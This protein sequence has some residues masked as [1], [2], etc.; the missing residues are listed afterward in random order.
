MRDQIA[1]AERLGIRAASIDST[2]QDD[3][4]EIEAALAADEVDVLLISPERL[5]NKR[6]LDRTLKAIPKGIGLFVV[7]EAHC[8][9]EWGHDFRP[10]YQRIRQIT[11]F[12]ARE[13]PC[14]A[15]TATANDRVVADIQGQLGPD[16]E[17]LSKDHWTR[18]SLYLAG[19]RAGRSS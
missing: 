3:W 14:P 15:T 16:L 11:E 1:M 4:D 10:D 9:S 17:I 18:D 12:L 2:N 13:R 7:D 5:G 8:I 6:F 19:D